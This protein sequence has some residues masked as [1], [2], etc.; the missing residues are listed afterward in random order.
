MLAEQVQMAHL[1]WELRTQELDFWQH[2]ELL[3]VPLGAAL[4]KWSKSVVLYQE[5]PF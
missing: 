2:N 4:S 3:K 1:S 5:E